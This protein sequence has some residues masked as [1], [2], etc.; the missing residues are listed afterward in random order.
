M[1]E[2]IQVSGS[3]TKPYAQR[4]VDDYLAEI[5]PAIA[6]QLTGEQWSEIRKV[7]KQAIPKPAPKIV[8]LRLSVDL[9]LSRFYIVLFV[10]KD[11]RRKPRKYRLSNTT[12]RI[13]NMIA[14]SLL[15]IGINLTITAALAIGAYLLKAAVNINLFPN[16]H[17]P[18]I[19]KEWF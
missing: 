5:D 3:K 15:L 6:N 9:I 17:L 1:R 18:E 8:D 2:R 19:L 13:G 7:L 12:T 4:T 16:R 14:A 11:R 10:G